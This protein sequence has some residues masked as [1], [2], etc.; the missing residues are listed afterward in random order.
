[1]DKTGKAG[2]TVVNAV[3]LGKDSKIIFTMI[4]IIGI[5]CFEYTAIM[6]FQSL[7]FPKGGAGSAGPDIDNPYTGIFIGLFIIFAGYFISRLII[8][9]RTGLFIGSTAAVTVLIPAAAAFIIFLPYG[10][11]RAIF[12]TSAAGVLYITGLRCYRTRSPYP[13]NEKTITFGGLITFFLLIAVYCIPSLSDLRAITLIMN[14]I[15]ILCAMVVRNQEQLM[16]LM[17]T[18]KDYHGGAKNIRS[19]NLFVVTIMFAAM[20]IIS[21]LQ[22]VIAFIVKL[23]SLAANLILRVVYFIF[24][25]FAS[26]MSGDSQQEKSSNPGLPPLPAGQPLTIIDTIV[27]IVIGTLILIFLIKKGPAI[28][29]WIKERLITFFRFVK[30]LFTP[31]EI[32]ADEEYFTD[33]IEII[34]PGASRRKAG[35]SYSSIQLLRRK[36]RLLAH[37]TETTEKVRLMYGIILFLLAQ[38][39]TEIKISV[40]GTITGSNT[41]EEIFALTCCMFAKADEQGQPVNRAK[42]LDSLK[43]LTRAYERVRYG[44]AV[45]ADEECDRLKK[46]YENIRKGLD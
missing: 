6:T 21:N 40:A 3:D 27:K 1:M 34:A 44:D 7:V 41:P 26:L 13:L 16:L 36:M 19:Y 32:A 15:F 22:F 43:T 46:H 14:Y 18:N 35:A 29:R 42:T 4:S 33:F 8:G 9:K 25:I 23:L 20:L 30:K 5:F 28:Y 12:E 11:L 17:G 2:K 24:H 37:A 39:L 45:P 10:S 38:K 31:N